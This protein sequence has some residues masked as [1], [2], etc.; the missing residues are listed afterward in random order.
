VTRPTAL[1]VGAE[2][3]LGAALCR[4]ETY[5]QIH[6]QHRSA[7]THEVDLRPFKEGL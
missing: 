2:R 4:R 5:W 6:R 1:V 3:G 7:W